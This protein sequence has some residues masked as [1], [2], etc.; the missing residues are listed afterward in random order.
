MDEMKINVIHCGDNLYIMRN[1][2]DE[3]VDLIYLDPPF[4]SNRHYE[5]IWGDD[6]E[7]RSFD[8]RWEGGIEHYI[9]W[10]KERLLEMHRILSPT[11]SIYLH[12]DWHAS[13]Y[14]KIEMDKIFGMKNF[15]NN[16][17][18]CYSNSGRSKKVFPK[19]HDDIFL[20]TKG[21]TYTFNPQKID[22][23]E[24]VK[25][26]YPL[27]DEDRQQYYRV[28][29]RG[30][31]GKY[32]EYCEK[33]AEDWW[34]DINSIGGRNRTERLGYPTQK[35][36]ALL[37]RIIKASSD[38]GDIVF[39]PFCGCATTIDAADRLGRDWIGIDISPR[40]CDVIADRLNIP[41]WQIEGMPMT[42]DDF[43]EMEPHEFQQWVCTRMEA[44]NTSHDPS[45]SSGAD[46]GID[47]I[48]KSNLLTTGYAGALL[49]VK[50][51]KGVGVDTILKHFAIMKHRKV[52]VGFV[53]ALSFG[54]GAIEQVAAYKNADDVEIILVKAEDIAERGYFC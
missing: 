25:K 34:V 26:Q 38:E 7:T 32:T 17:V 16:I 35:P 46:G 36:I 1:M 50:R 27:F 9:G 44:R 39:D 19:K 8:D 5:V 49:Q 48:V 43:I 41:H 12:C 23:A 54:R 52:D 20:Y 31:A 3:S 47:G 40:A 51:S 30:K 14:L 2:P 22:V 15:R 18:W 21:S 42:T 53:V 11:G 10:M 29:S 24:Q 33:Y 37:E 4:F 13:H 45:K 6:N 28:A